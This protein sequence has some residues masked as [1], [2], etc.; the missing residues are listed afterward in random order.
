M[1][2]KESHG[3]F[4]KILSSSFLQPTIVLDKAGRKHWGT[5]CWVF[6]GCKDCKWILQALGEVEAMEP[7]MVRSQAKRR[8]Y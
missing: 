3:T 8:L 7:G 6:G 5:G 4:Q 1:S 2:S